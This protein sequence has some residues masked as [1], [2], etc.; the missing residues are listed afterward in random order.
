MDIGSL[1]EFLDP[2]PVCSSSDGLPSILERLKQH[3]GDRILVVGDRQIAVGLLSASQVLPYLV[4]SN[5]D[6]EALDPLVPSPQSSHG[7]NITHSL[8]TAIEIVWVEFGHALLEPVVML[9]VDS[10]IAQAQTYLRGSSKRNC[11]LVDEFGHPLGL[12][13][14]IKFWQ[15]LADRLMP[16]AG[17]FGGERGD[18]IDDEPDGVQSCNPPLGH[19]LAERPAAISFQGSLLTAALRLLEQ[20]P[21]P[22]RVQT[23]SGQVVSQNL[24]WQQQVGALDGEFGFQFEVDRVLSIAHGQSPLGGSTFYSTQGRS[25]TAAVHSERDANLIGDLQANSD[26]SLCRLG[27]EPNTCVCV[28]PAHDGDDQVWKFTKVP[29]HLSLSQ[30]EGNQRRSPASFHQTHGLDA[31]SPV[32]LGA[33]DLGALD[34]ESQT[35]EPLDVDRLWLVLAQDATRQQQATQE[36]TAKN[37]DLVQTNRLKDEFLVGISHELKNPLTSILGL[38]GL[39]REQKLGTLNDRQL[40]YADLIHQSGRRLITIVNDMLDLTRIEMGQIRLSFDLVGIS[41]VCQVAYQQ[42]RHL[43]LLGESAHPVDHDSTA[44]Q[45]AFSLDIEPGLEQ[46]VADEVRLRQMLVQLIAN[47]IKFTPVDGAI[48]IRVVSWASWV[49]FTIWDTGVG[50]PADQQYLIFQKFQQIEHPLTRQFEGTGLGLV[51]TQRLAQLHGGDVSF[52]STEG[53]GSEF[54]LLLP[55]Y[56]H[57]ADANQLTPTHPDAARLTP[58]QNRLVLVVEAVPSALEHS[59]TVLMN[60][61]YRV[62]I[63]R[64][65]TEAISKI[66]QLQPLA[67]LLNPDLPL[68]SGWD[69]LVLMKTDPQISKIPVVVMAPASE[70][71]LARRN[72]VTG[73]L[74][75][76]IRQNALEQILAAIPPPQI[77]SPQ[78]ECLANLTILHLK[79]PGLSIDAH[80]LLAQESLDHASAIGISL[81]HDSSSPHPQASSLDLNHL[82]H[83]YHC[84]VLEVDDLDQAELLARVWKPDVMLIDGAIAKPELLVQELAQNSYLAALPL[85]TLTPKVTQ[86]ANQISNLAVFPCLE[87]YLSSVDWTESAQVSALIQVIQVATGRIQTP[88][89]LLADLMAL[90]V[91]NSPTASSHADGSATLSPAFISS[92]TWPQ[93][94]MRYV[95]AAGFRCSTALSWQ[96]VLDQVQNHHVDGLILYVQPESL[97]PTSLTMLNRLN[98]VTSLPPVLVLDGG[99]SSLTDCPE[100]AAVIRE[101]RAIAT[102]I[103]PTSMPMDRLL[104]ILHHL[105]VEIRSEV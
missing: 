4:L 30:L 18:E 33:L 72:G 7:L 69:V 48:G 71:K 55:A 25:P 6:L 44:P 96:N 95:R 60:L 43:C 78:N 89:I 8:A 46:I 17:E 80:E 77:T 5:S 90:S 39:L 34:A 24:A 29:L 64:S 38:S 23:S 56:P 92:D 83:P 74:P 63:A 57:D 81:P 3:S 93:M 73:F 9:A 51:L 27:D 61:G 45:L 85:V 28:Y 67:I 59:T 50:I 32:D 16:H 10:S 68:L 20:L 11:I 52:I 35:A 65:G 19:R 36:L 105:L 87:L 15:Q 101:M 76:P 2:I 12:L 54:T 75:L 42:A 31:N 91:S 13:N 99:C 94:F 37:A 1:H 41:D 98:Q 86:A 100:P 58:S 103:V 97:V 53:T 47:A 84:R 66:R 49:A 79:V 104:D 26:S 82:L 102:Q 22:L 88:H 21:L 62:A 70:G 14:Q 40:R